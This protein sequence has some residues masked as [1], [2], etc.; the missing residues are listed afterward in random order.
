M[1]TLYDCSS[2]PSPRRTRIF[3]AEKGVK[4]ECKQV[5]LAKREQMSE[6]FTALNPRRP[7]PVLV[8]E[9]RKPLSQHLAIA[10]YIEQINTKPQLM[11]TEDN[12]RAVA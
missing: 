11:E 4:Y 6:A 12:P 5:D 7:V 10:F 9:E 1:L 8:T 2:A 3:L